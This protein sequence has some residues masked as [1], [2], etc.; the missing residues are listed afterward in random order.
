VGPSA[1]FC[2][3][4]FKPLVTPL[5]TQLEQVVVASLTSITN[6]LMHAASGTTQAHQRARSP[7]VPSFKAPFSV[8][9]SQLV[10]IR[11]STCTIF[12]SRFTYLK[13]RF[14]NL[15]TCTCTFHS[16]IYLLVSDFTPQFTY[17][18]EISLPNLLTCTRFHS[19]IYLLVRDFTPQFTY[20][21]EIS[22]PNLLE[23]MELT[24]L[25]NEIQTNLK[26]N[27]PNLH[28]Q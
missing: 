24:Y 4:W 11:Q 9:L 6:A 19:P 15:L 5:I 10:E 16:P 21:Y 13:I 22:L 17:L 8:S 27:S 23:R 2:T 1:K 25:I 3:P 18:Y 7:L 20:L 14:P 26:F 12:H 28:A